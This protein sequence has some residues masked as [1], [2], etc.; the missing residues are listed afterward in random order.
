M[1]ISGPSADSG[2]SQATRDRIIF[3]LWLPLI[4]VLNGAALAAVGLGIG[5]LGLGVRMAIRG[6]L[7]DPSAFGDISGIG[8]IAEDRMFLLG[9]AVAILGLY[10]LLANATFGSGTVQDS[11]QTAEEAKAIRNGNGDDESDDSDD[12]SENSG[13]NA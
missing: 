10:W 8:A 9:I 12:G 13:F 2:V 7:P 3:A 5:L 11:I 1:E 6:E 4:L